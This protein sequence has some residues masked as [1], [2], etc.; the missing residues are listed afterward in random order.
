MTLPR[1]LCPESVGGEYSGGS[2]K[3]QV[4]QVRSGEPLEISL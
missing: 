3:A 2:E 1:L 4:V